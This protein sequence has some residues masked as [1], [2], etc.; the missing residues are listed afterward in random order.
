M[1][2]TQVNGEITV[3]MSK[4]PTPKL[5]KQF[6]DMLWVNSPRSWIIKSVFFQNTL[7]VSAILQISEDQTKKIRRSFQMI[8][9]SQRSKDLWGLAA[10]CIDEMKREMN[11]SDKRKS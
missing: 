11:D 2:V 4:I 10:D 7:F 3:K 1:I 6:E 5:A 8:V 9:L